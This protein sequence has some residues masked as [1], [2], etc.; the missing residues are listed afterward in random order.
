[1]L[2]HKS[3]SK[4]IA[5]ESF[6]KFGKSFLIVG[7]LVVACLSGCTPPM[8]PEVK[9]ALS[10]EVSAC[11]ADGNLTVNAPTQYQD[12]IQVFADDYTSECTNS[13]VTIVDDNSPADISFS[14]LELPT[15][16]EIV[17][18]G[19][20]AYDAATLVYTQYSLSELN[21]KPQTLS[22]LLAGKISDWADKKLLADN[23]DS[24][25]TSAPIKLQQIADSPALAALNTW[26]HQVDSANWQDSTALKAVD[27]WDRDAAL[28]AAMEENS[29]SVMPLSVASNNSLTTASILLAGQTYPTVT[30]LAATFAA[31]GQ[32]KVVDE[33]SSVIRTV[34]DPN[35]PPS[36]ADGAD[37]ASQPWQALYPVNE[38]ICKGTQELAARAFARFILRLNEQTQN[39][40]YSVARVPEAIRLLTAGVI[41]QGLP[42][43]S[44]TPE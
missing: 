4:Q 19:P 30:D 18:G 35:L 6:V 31:T 15:N 22:E 41:E 28:T 37:Q 9:A 3:T 20:I 24:G 23:P 7:A 40:A 1:M 43:P 38:Y 12:L 21:L 5:M 17:A 33:A 13:T 34:I 10:E 42:T 8:P 25:L 14:D 36:L 27:S 29:V 16:C 2:V 44:A 39:E 11:V 26:G 32:L